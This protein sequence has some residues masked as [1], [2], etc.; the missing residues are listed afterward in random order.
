MV[1]DVL[2]LERRRHPDGYYRR[3]ILPDATSTTHRDRERK[4]MSELSD[5]KRMVEKPTLDKLNREISALRELCFDA[6][7]C[8]DVLGASIGGIAPPDG[9]IG[10]WNETS[11]QLERIGAAPFAKRIVTRG[12]ENGEGTDADY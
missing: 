3:V 2:L 8:L 1:S 12:N 7:A 11:V 9:F 4:G 6:Y 5:Y 10:L